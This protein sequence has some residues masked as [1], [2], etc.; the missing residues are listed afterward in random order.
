MIGANGL[1]S[2]GALCRPLL[3]DHWRLDG[4]GLLRL[5][6]GRLNRARILETI[7]RVL[8]LADTA[9]KG[10]SNLRQL[11]RAEHQQDNDQQNNDFGAVSYAK[12]LLCSLALGMLYGGM[13]LFL[14]SVVYPHRQELPH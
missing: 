6:Q 7:R 11:A 14:Q 3:L 13:I 4:A 12:H 5:L 1:S 2:L 8:E 9:S 10:R